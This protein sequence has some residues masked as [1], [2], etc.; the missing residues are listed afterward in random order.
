M[1]YIDEIMERAFDNFGK[2]INANEYSFWA[3]SSLIEAKPSTGSTEPDT[4][5]QTQEWEAADESTTTTTTTTDWSSTEKATPATDSTMS[6]V[7]GLAA[8]TEIADAVSEVI[9]DV[10]PFSSDSDSNMFT[11]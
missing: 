3:P 5:T 1:Y 11:T 2:M 6:D 9:E 4:T 10:N 7:A 8:A